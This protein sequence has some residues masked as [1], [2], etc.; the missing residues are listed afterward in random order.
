MEKSPPE[1]IERF[2]T[3]AAEFPEATRRLTFGYPCLYVGGNMVSGLYQ[4]GWHVRLAGSD[5]AAAQ[6]LDGAHTFDFADEVVAV[7]VPASEKGKEPEK[8]TAAKP[9][10]DPGAWTAIVEDTE[11]EYRD[12]ASRNKPDASPK[13]PAPQ[14]PTTGKQPDETKSGQHKSRRLRHSGHQSNA[15]GFDVKPIVK[16][17]NRQFDSA[18]KATAVIGFSIA[19]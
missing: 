14:D 6:A 19:H 15:S 8:A 2:D 5:L 18:A 9:A 4:D 1:L 16:Y 13:D 11:D 10:E 7:E 12:P 3:V 17:I